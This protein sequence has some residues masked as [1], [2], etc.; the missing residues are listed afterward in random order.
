MVHDQDYY[1]THHSHCDKRSHVHLQEF[2][3]LNKSSFHMVPAIGV[4]LTIGV[5]EQGP[6]F[7][8]EFEQ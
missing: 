7:E 1:D 4:D 2:D 8:N 5:L 3:I 6:C